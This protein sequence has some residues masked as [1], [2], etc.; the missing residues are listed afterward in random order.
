MVLLIFCLLIFESI[1]FLKR[2]YFFGSIGNPYGDVNPTDMFF[3][4]ERIIDK[5]DVVTFCF[6]NNIEVL[7][8]YDNQITIDKNTFT[9]ALEH[10]SL[11]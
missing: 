6:P 5:M 2:L 10:R 7:W 4:K 3:K 8:L 11:E 9:S 1:Y